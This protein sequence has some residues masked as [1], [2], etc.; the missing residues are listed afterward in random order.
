MQNNQKNDF[1]SV[2]SWRKTMPVFVIGFLGVALS[3]MAFVSVVTT[4]REKVEIDF[5]NKAE[6]HGIFIQQS[7]NLNSQ[8]VSSIRSLFDASSF[9]TREEFNIFTNQ[10]ILEN[11]GI[12]AIEWAPLI[13][14]TERE[15]FVT[16]THNKGLADYRITEIT[17]TGD[18]KIADKRDQYFPVHYINPL[19]GNEP[20]L[21]LDLGSN[22]ARKNALLKA[23]NSGEAVASE[24]I[25]LV[26]EAGESYAVLLF[27]PVFR[28]NK[29]IGNAESLYGFAVGVFNIADMVESILS[30]ML[31]HEAF[32]IYFFDT[33]LRGK[34]K[35]IHHYSAED[36]SSASSSA[37]KSIAEVKKGLHHVEKLFFADREWT[38]IF[39]PQ[40]NFQQIPTSLVAWSVLL[41]GF[42]ITYLLI[43][44]MFSSIRRS[45]EIRKHVED[46]TRVLLI[47][48]EAL[49]KEIEEKKKAETAVEQKNIEL[50][51]AVKQAEA[52]AKA[53]SMF[54]ATMSHE[55]R[56]P[57]NGVLGMA[58]L[59]KKTYLAEKQQ[60]YLNTMV[61]S[62]QTLMNIVNDILDFS[63]IE[64]GELTLNKVD[65]NPNTI[66]D[67]STRLYSKAA[68]DK[69][70]ELIISPL[71]GLET[72]LV[73]DVDRLIQ[74][75][76]NLVSNAIK[77]TDKG[78]VITSAHIFDETDEGCRLRFTVTDTG[79]GIAKD[80]QQDLFVSFK[81][82]ESF[83]TR[84]QGGTGLGLAISKQLVELMGGEIGVESA[85]GT[86][87][88]FW[89]EIPFEKGSKRQSRASY[90]NA[91]NKIFK[92][93]IADKSH[94]HGQI[95][96]KTLSRWNFDC[97][98][99][100]SPL[101][102]I[103]RTRSQH[104]TD[105]III[106]GAI[107]AENDF[108]LLNELQKLETDH[109]PRILILVSESDT[110]FTN[111]G[112][113]FGI[114]GFVYKP[115]RSSQLFDTLAT[116]L[117]IDP[118]ACKPSP[119]GER[120]A[121]DHRTE[122][123]LIVDDVT[124]NQMV[125]RGMLDQFGF[126]SQIANNGIEAVSVATEFPFDLIFMDISMP[127]M[128]GYEATRRI[129]EGLSDKS[130]VII[131]LTAHA[132]K[133]EHEKA[134]ASGMDEVLTKPVSA[135]AIKQALDHWLPLKKMEEAIHPQ[136]KN[137]KIEM[138]LTD[139]SESILASLDQS[140]IDRL[141]SELGPNLGLIIDAYLDELPGR[142]EDLV[143]AISNDDAQQLWSDAHKLKGSSRNL[144]A[145]ILGKLCMELEQVGKEGHLEKADDLISK[146]S[147]EALKVEEALRQLKKN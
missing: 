83:S 59:L 54:L 15:K 134:M 105:L 33:T 71:A 44:Y 112:K 32:E 56:T 91:E 29:G 72:T 20:A 9:V 5:V 74:V 97:T 30:Q 146:I 102:T 10:M 16:D 39:T 113:E 68:E 14:D 70:I 124:V 130:P 22:P 142:V 42:A 12:K 133:E 107:A 61:H 144:G 40:R 115:V 92:A 75:M 120:T 81:Q 104:N 62:G 41:G 99:T 118:A 17:D 116:I 49:E 65:F 58:E 45:D 52:A 135:D 119:I 121:P 110:V 125:V 1:Y 122:Q 101:E 114:D 27:K 88:S 47:T 126:Q 117:A 37:P 67:H 66:I 35:F 46:A 55:I 129:K 78:E 108:T 13:N 57:L 145:N 94:T 60:D 85:P 123:I 111:K 64:A 23:W 79:I 82:L 21:G 73:G 140:V 31:K 98:L 109:K 136:Q 19:E 100:E 76:S 43:A 25:K 48:N 103:V 77:F 69:G 95:L 131:G 34:P 80:K 4:E 89:F 87:S 147:E 26:Q 63:K 3:I 2:A 141:T 138:S 24:P 86:G 18:L 8:T 143:K 53:K 50:G 36:L 139:D 51:I 127:E 106:D 84:K 93:I 38:A 11:T 137:E 6:S 128:D 28:K 7:I 96:I 132:L 90:F